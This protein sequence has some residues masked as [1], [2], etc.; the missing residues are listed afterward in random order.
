MVQVQKGKKKM[1]FPEMG[2]HEDWT[3]SSIE[4]GGGRFQ[5]CKED[6]SGVLLSCLLLELKLFECCFRF[7]F[8]MLS[9]YHHLTDKQENTP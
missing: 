2:V 4:A 3:V 9:G 7:D 1:H 5:R 6:V 8:W